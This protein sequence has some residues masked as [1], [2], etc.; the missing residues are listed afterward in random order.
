MERTDPPTVY[1]VVDPA[2]GQ[3]LA[4]RFPEPIWTPLPFGPLCPHRVVFSTV[5]DA[6]AWLTG[7]GYSAERFRIEPAGPAA[8]HQ[9]AAAS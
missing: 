7:A 4:S 2:S 3:R 8:E 1:Q 6:A 5:G 9:E